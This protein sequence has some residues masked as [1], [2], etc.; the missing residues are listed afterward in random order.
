V[1]KAAAHSPQLHSIPPAQ[2]DGDQIEVPP[3][4][5]LKSRASVQAGF[6][7]LLPQTNALTDL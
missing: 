6:F 3:D 1:S 5:A 7:V 2:T 4:N